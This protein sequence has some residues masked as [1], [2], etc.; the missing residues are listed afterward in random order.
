MLHQRGF[1]ASEGGHAGQGVAAMGVAPDSRL[2]H[3][4]GRIVHIGDG[5]GVYTL[6]LLELSPVAHVRSIELKPRDH[7]TMLARSALTGVVLQMNAVIILQ[8]KV[9]FIVVEAVLAC[10][11]YRELQLLA[12]TNP[13]PQLRQWR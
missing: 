5:A 8:I 4:I 9:D 1:L 13:V 11:D 7:R 6:G 3:I 12:E 10:Y 2:I